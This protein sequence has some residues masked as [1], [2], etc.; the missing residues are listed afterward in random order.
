MSIPVTLSQQT[1]QRISQYATTFKLSREEA[2]DRVINEFMD[3]AG[4]VRIEAA[5]RILAA[6]EVVSAMTL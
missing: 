6:Q 2:V 1:N 5:S 3:E 4:D